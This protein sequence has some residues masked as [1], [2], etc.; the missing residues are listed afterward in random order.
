[1]ASDIGDVHN[2]SDSL[3]QVKTSLAT[4]MCGLLGL[5]G[6][7]LEQPQEQN[8]NQGIP[9]PVGDHIYLYRTGRNSLKFGNSKQITVN[10]W[11]QYNVT[12]WYI[13]MTCTM[14]YICLSVHLEYQ[15][16]HG[17]SFFQCDVF[18]TID[19]N[20]FTLNEQLLNHDNPNYYLVTGPSHRKIHW[21]KLKLVRILVGGSLFCPPDSPWRVSSGWGRT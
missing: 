11:T 6:L 9:T 14:R 1:M 10:R 13:S 5:S 12:W 20:C 15:Y 17:H 16:F 2:F 7:L 3:D 4:S 8:K 18:W 19:T 21:I